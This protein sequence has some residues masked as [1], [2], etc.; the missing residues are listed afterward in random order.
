MF[1]THF[2]LHSDPTTPPPIARASQGSLGAPLDGIRVLVFDANH[3]EQEVVEEL[4]RQRGA[5]VLGVDSLADALEQLEGWRPDVLMT[6]GQHG[7]DSSYSL[8]TKLPGLDAERGGRIP[9]LALTRF[10]RHDR[11]V[12]TMLADNV[13]D[14]PKP[15]EPALL[16]AE[17]ARLTGRER[18]ATCR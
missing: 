4:L 2:P 13:T 10:S 9:A 6:S 12:R 3:D 15:V 5:S 16:T 14:L 7:D 17:I 1:T 18:R 8:V 11:E